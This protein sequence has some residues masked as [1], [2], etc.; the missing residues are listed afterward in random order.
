M[1]TLTCRN[2]IVEF[3]ADYVDGTLSPEIAAELERHLQAC[4]A[5]MAYLNTYRKTR[6]LVGRHEAQTVMPDEMKT[7]LRRFLLERLPKKTP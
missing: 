6:D 7:I 4:A 5:C 3:L 1:E 2:V